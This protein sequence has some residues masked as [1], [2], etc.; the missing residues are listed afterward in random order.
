M[1]P[2]L[3]T[4][5]FVVVAVVARMVPR[6]LAYLAGRLSGR[7][8]IERY[9]RKRPTSRLQ[10][11]VPVSERL[12]QPAAVLAGGAP[13]SALAGALGIGPWHFTLLNLAGAV[14]PT[15]LLVLF[16]AAAAEPLNW[17]ARAVQDHPGVWQTAVAV[18]VVV[19]VTGELTRRLIRRRQLRRRTG[20]PP[21][22]PA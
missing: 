19:L 6:H 20:R 22:P 14:F 7:E 18:G 11:V 4:A 21:G 3:S 2:Q 10:R 13:T 5:L 1:L 17:T 12:V 16:G 9:L 8:E 15:M